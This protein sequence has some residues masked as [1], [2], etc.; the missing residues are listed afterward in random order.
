[1]VEFESL[2]SRFAT[3]VRTGDGAGLAALFTED[4]VY[5]D[6]FYG[7]FH[8]RSAIARMLTEHFHGTAQDF[9]W[10]LTH[11]VCDGTVGHARYVFSYTP[12]MEGA[13]GDRVVFEGAS[14]F[15]LEDALIREYS[16]VFDTGVALSQL[17]F[18]EERIGRSLAKRAAD[19][20]SRHAGPP[21]FTA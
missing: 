15:L 3:A 4:G 2:L 9:V 11:P 19:L 18:P 1:M 5:E 10:E 6:G 17:G 21:H 16:E 14:R 20:R 12:T 13:T 8:G 7:E